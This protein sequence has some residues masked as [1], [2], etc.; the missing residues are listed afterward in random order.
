MLIA[1]FQKVETLRLNYRK[2]KES[3][4]IFKN[5]LKIKHIKIKFCKSNC[6]SVLL[7]GAQS[8]KITKSI[9]QN[10]DTIQSKCLRNTLK[11]FGQKNLKCRTTP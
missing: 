1:K 5:Y 3:I 10:S 11:I 2:A 6:L 7:Y 9:C 8:W 4:W